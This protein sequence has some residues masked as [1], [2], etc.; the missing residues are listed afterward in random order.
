[1][2]PNI[3]TAITINVTILLLASWIFGGMFIRNLAAEKEAL[4]EKLNKLRKQKPPTPALTTSPTIEPRETDAAD[5]A[6][7]IDSMSR[8]IQ[9]KEERINKLLALKNSQQDVQ[10]SLK[11]ENGDDGM[12]A[13]LEQLESGFKEMER[14]ILSLESDL[15]KSRIA[16]SS[17]EKE[18]ANGQTH[19]ARVFALEKAERRLRNDNK[20]LRENGIK[21]AEKLNLRNTQVNNL[22]EDNGKLKKSIASL[23]NAS[24]EQLDVIKK[25]HSQIERAE[26]LESYQRQL[27][28]DLEGRLNTEKD[29]GNDTT[30]VQ[31]MEVELENLR[32]TLKRT[33]I[34]KEFIEE[35]MLELDD[36]LEKAKIT[37]AALNRAQQEIESLEQYYPE[38]TPPTETETEEHLPVAQAPFTTDIP[39]LQDIMD[40]NRLFGS[41]LEFWTT[42]DIPPLNLMETQKVPRPNINDW[43]HLTIGNGDYSVLMTI[44]EGLADVVTHAIF[45]GGNN[46]DLD[47]KDTRGELGNIIAG[48]LA[49]EL[50]NDFAVSVPQHL[51][52]GEAKKILMNSTVVSE[53]L[54]IAQEK[55][56]YAALIIPNAP[57]NPV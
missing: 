15:N 16:L 41:I 40:N 14:I 8:D 53:I 34:E 35:H 17:M 33:L 56:L 21:I 12:V 10:Q 48:T 52:L 51:N 23:S 11:T 37:E 45:K 32:D 38:Y 19:S 18:M 44:D 31:A 30:K 20:I 13:Y 24:K 36:T 27:I 46:N 55:P 1:L 9:E 6:A 7:L 57:E 5:Y 4:R 26:K 3:L 54:A 42:L 2:N 25:L 29:D 49:T 22:K 47:Q 43:V 50:D 28:N 39:E